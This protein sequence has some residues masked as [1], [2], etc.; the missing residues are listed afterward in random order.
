MFDINLVCGIFELSKNPLLLDLLN[1][2]V[3][4]FV[5]M[6]IFYSREKKN[7]LGQ[8]EDPNKT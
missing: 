2:H 7:I 8:Y 3:I 1:P 5:V 4:I 6:L